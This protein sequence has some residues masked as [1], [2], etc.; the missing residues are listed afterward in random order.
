MKLVMDRDNL[1]NTINN[2]P[3]IQNWTVEYTK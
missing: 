3:D 1:L 2:S